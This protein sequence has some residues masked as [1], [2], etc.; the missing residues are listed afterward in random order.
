MTMPRAKAARL[1]TLPFTLLCN[2]WF[3]HA[4]GRTRNAAALVVGVYCWHLAGRWRRRHD[5]VV[6]ATDAAWE[7]GVGRTTFYAA[8]QLLEQ[9]GL[10][11]VLRRPRHGC[12]VTLPSDEEISTWSEEP[13]R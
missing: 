2:P 1:H 4:Y 7:F 5:L 9:A 8:L 13:A 3:A 10:L 12:L 11:R 6:T